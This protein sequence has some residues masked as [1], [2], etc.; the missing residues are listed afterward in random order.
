MIRKK[1][2]LSTVCFLAT[3]I[4]T[5]CF[6]SSTS[7][8]ARAVAVGQGKVAQVF[9]G[10]KGQIII[11]EESHNSRV[12]QIEI[13]RM[14][15]RLYKHHGLRAVGLEGA[16]PSDGQLRPRWTERLDSKSRLRVAARLLGEGEI[17]SA[18]F[19]ATTFPDIMVKGIDDPV[20]YK[21]EIGS[22][23]AG[24]GTMYL[25]RIAEQ[26]LKPEQIANVNKLVEG[27]KID[28]AIKLIIGSDPW[29][30]K[31]HA[32]MSRQ[33]P[34]V[35][36]SED[37][38]RHL[39]DVE[40][41]A[42]SRNIAIDA[43][44]A[45]GMR[46]LKQFFRAASERNGPM[47][48]ET[49]AL[50][51]SAATTPGAMIIGAAHTAGVTRLLRE[52]GYSFT[53]ITPLALTVCSEAN[54]LEWSAYERKTKGQSVDKTGLGSILDGRRKPQPIIQKTWVQSKANTYY[55]ATMIARAASGGEKPPFGSLRG[56]DNLEG[57]RINRS[58]FRI[59]NTEV[60]FQA[61][62]QDQNGQ[63]QSIWVRV[64]CETSGCNGKFFSNTNANS[65]DR[66]I[67]ELIAEA[68]GGGGKDDPPSTDDKTV[69]SEDPG[70]KG[71]SGREKGK[72]K[73]ARAG[74]IEIDPG[75]FMVMSKERS[76]VEKRVMLGAS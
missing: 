4:Q 29:T 33:C 49:V 66:R 61:S 75:V 51:N 60:I 54:N 26:S 9:D 12:G 67:D 3:T 25:V 46:E 30:K 70:D 34:N 72:G 11:F 52:S 40:S 47:V 71:K 56:L 5:P 53:V 13:A 15:V 6:S 19:I 43:K 42:K 8:I 37:M 16:F 23:S 20:R 63:W 68:G 65:I 64:G 69:A 24:A 73:K 45:G 41:E 62:V 44:A 2:V 36:S 74:A 22:D 76:A 10:K 58:T 28:Q 21:V 35:V 1:Y 14:L 18:E 31:K 39:S 32:Q 55:A 27:K 59:E 48:R 50:I 38:L 57:L 17:S 7:E